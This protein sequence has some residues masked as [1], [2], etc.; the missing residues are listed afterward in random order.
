M[1]SGSIIPDP[2]P[3]RRLNLMSRISSKV[4]YLWSPSP[5]AQHGFSRLPPQS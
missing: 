2:E 5:S 4:S 1:N 3:R